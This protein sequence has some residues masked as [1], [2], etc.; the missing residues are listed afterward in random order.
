MPKG[1]AR[2]RPLAVVGLLMGLVA[3]NA[4]SYLPQRLNGMRGLYTIRRANLEPFL[5]EEAQRWTPALVIVETDTWMAYGNLLVLEDTW[6]TTSWIFAWSRGP[7]ADLRVAKAFPDRFVLRYNPN[8]PY[9]LGV[10][11]M[12]QR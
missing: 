8:K 9:R 5:T 3:W 7:S 12:P 2:Y 10:W 6:L 11:R 1:Y 4:V